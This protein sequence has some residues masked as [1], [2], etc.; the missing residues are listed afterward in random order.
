M[1]AR[2]ASGYRS[3]SIRCRPSRAAL[4]H[5]MGNLAQQLGLVA[6]RLQMAQSL[7]DQC[8]S[9]VLGALEPQD[10]DE[11]RLAGLGI[12]ADRLAGLGGGAFLVQEIV[13]DLEREPDVMGVIVQLPAHFRR[14]LA[15]DGARLAR[16]GDERAGL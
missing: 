10:R 3:S 11:G 13:G 15:E 4:D 8:P 12:A 7:V 5:E 16:E 6:E 14:R 1:V 2:T 9:L